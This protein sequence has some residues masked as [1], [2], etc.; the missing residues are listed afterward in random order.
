MFFFV[1]LCDIYLAF[2]RYSVSAKKS[3]PPI[4]RIDTNKKQDQ[5][6]IREEREGTL[7]AYSAKS[8]E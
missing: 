1:A 4:T 8:E 5:K 3:Y 2:S 7:R 6:R